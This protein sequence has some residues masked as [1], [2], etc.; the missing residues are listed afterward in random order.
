M[1]IESGLSNIHWMAH[2]Y[3]KDRKIRRINF[4][5]SPSEE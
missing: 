5:S 2:I 4:I 1:I 3:S